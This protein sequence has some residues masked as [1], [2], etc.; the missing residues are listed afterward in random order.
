MK[1]I[2]IVQGEGRGHMT[3]AISLQE[4]LVS[5]GHEVSH[6]FLGR[7]SRRD[8]PQF[9]TER[10][11]E[12]EVEGIASPNFI[13]DKDNKSVKVVPSILKNLSK[14]KPF[15]ES[16]KRIHEVVETKKP[17]AIV[18]FYDF[19]GGIYNWKY[20]PEAKFFCIGHQ[21]LMDH[22]DF[23]FAKGGPLDKF[24]IL[25]ANRITSWKADKLI[26]LSFTDYKPVPNLTVVPPLLR[27]ELSDL[28]TSSE[29]FVLVYMV[30]DGY[31]DE[32]KQFHEK[33]PDIRL[34]CFWDRKGAPKED[35]IDE[36]LTFHQLDD[37]KFLEKMASC[38]AYASTA[39]FESVCEAMYLGKPVMMVPVNK[40]YEQACNAIDGSNAGA[41][42]ASN[43]FNI[44]KLIDYIPEHKDI[45]ESF[46]KWTE[47]TESKILEA[48]T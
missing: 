12:V 38:I 19:I 10:L 4:M 45:S 31:G 25:R 33:N 36:T 39:G 2:F 11:S 48:L 6:I 44:S 42:I 41:G 16:L 37:K 46:K 1:F 40:Q 3:Q 14:L 32:V 13:T 22:P 34:F 24:F 18:N 30:N 29:D 7:S 17:D 9:F 28:K 47:Q 21:Y 20:K 27:K 26:A 15:K 8:I 23:P 35:K 43:E 5:A